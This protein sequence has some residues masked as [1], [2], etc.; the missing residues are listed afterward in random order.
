MLRA[1]RIAFVRTALGCCGRVTAA[2]ARK[3]TSYKPLVVARPAP[4]VEMDGIGAADG[5]GKPALW[6]T[7]A[8]ALRLGA[9]P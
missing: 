5:P 2:P 3:S 6:R 8:S 7:L 4:T 9:Q 1:E